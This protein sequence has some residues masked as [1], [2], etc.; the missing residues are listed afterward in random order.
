MDIWPCGKI[1][2]HFTLYGKSRIFS[3]VKICKNMAKHVS[4]MCVGLEGLTMEG[5]LAKKIC[6]ALHLVWESANFLER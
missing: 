3:H 4:R 2:Q 6:A 5:K 1:E